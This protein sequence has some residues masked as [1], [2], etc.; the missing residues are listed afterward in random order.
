MEFV[1]LSRTGLTLSR[2]CLGTGTS[3]SA[4][5]ARSSNRLAGRLLSDRCKHSH[6]REKGLFHLNSVGLEG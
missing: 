1:K 3:G 2:M 4:S 5:S 6:T